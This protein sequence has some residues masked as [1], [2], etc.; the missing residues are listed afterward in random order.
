MPL[1]SYAD[2]SD[3]E[4][5]ICRRDNW[6]LVFGS[7]FGRMESVRESLQRRYP[8]RICTMHARPITNEDELLLYVEVK[9]LGKV[10]KL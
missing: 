3:Y 9:R 8:I 4:K 10:F 6:R 1:I 2:F 5:I 7:F